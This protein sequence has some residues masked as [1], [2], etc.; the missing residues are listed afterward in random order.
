MPPFQPSFQSKPLCRFLTEDPLQAPWRASTS[1][2]YPCSP[3]DLLRSSTGYR[4]PPENSTPLELLSNPFSQEVLLRRPDTKEQYFYLLYLRSLQS[5]G[6]SKYY[7]KTTH[8]SMPCVRNKR[9]HCTVHRAE[10]PRLNPHP[11]QF[12]GSRVQGGVNA[13]VTL[14]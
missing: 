4:L 12:Q 2:R 8:N 1:S 5:Q 14:R 11:V 9:R 7:F 13:R 6:R 10:G 3:E